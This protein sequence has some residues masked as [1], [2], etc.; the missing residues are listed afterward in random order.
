MMK[1]CIFFCVLAIWATPVV[2][3]GAPQNAPAPSA[4]CNT[5]IFNMV[6]CLSFVSNGS[7]DSKP[8]GSCCS[9]LKTVLKAE[10]ECICEAFKNSAQLG[11]VLNVTKAITLP[12]SCGVSAPS[13]SNCELSTA[14]GASPGQSPSP[15]SAPMPPTADT[16]ATAPTGRISDEAPASAPT[17][18]GASATTIS[19]VALVSI[20]VASFSYF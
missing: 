2:N 20:V 3:S 1:L 4:D 13:L 14:P 11:V 9:G 18:S 10:P 8:Q 17:H 12:A 5:L 15:K 6:D 19:F 7:T 16:P